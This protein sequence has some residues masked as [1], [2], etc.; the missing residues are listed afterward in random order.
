MCEDSVELLLTITVGVLLHGQEEL[1]FTTL[2]E[3]VRIV[4]EK[5]IAAVELI[6]ERSGDVE[7]L[8]AV[9]LDVIRAREAEALEKQT[10]ALA[11][12]GK[13]VT[14][15]A[16]ELMNQL[17]KTYEAEWDTTS[18]N[19]TVIGIKVHAPY[20]PDNVEGRDDRARGRIQTIVSCIATC[21]V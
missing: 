19:L 3:N 10:K 1:E 17:A 13:G 7:P 12:V 2:K 5:A 6:E 16:Q 4:K 15:F 14:P 11:R 9:D 18:I 21:C 20:S 8:P